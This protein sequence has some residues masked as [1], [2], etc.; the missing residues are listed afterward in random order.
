MPANSNRM[1]LLK[2]RPAGEPSEDNFDLAEAPI[3]EPGEEEVA[4]AAAKKKG[5]R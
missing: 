2:S 3:P 1:V 5:K 4:T